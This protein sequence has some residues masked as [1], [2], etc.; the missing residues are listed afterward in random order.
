M[1]F[2]Q[3][4]QRTPNYQISKSE[5]R[6][7]ARSFTAQMRIYHGDII[8]NLKV[9]AGHFYFSGFFTVKETQQIF[10]FSISDVRFFQVK[11]LLI[12]TAKSYNDFSGGVN[13]SIPLDSE[14]MIRI[15]KFILQEGKK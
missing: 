11:N 6:G 9:H 12:R 14:F 13:Q 8:E 10:Y 5:F 1:R 2:L 4:L 3:Q 7:I 15:R